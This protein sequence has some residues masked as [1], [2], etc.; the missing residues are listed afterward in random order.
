[1]SL[2]TYHHKRS[3]S[4]TPEPKGQPHT[5]KSKPLHFVVQ[6]HHASRLHYDFRLEMEGVLKSWAIPKGPTMDPDDKPLAVQVEDHPFEYRTFEGVIPEGQYGAGTVAIWDEGTYSS[7]E[8]GKD[9]EKKLLAGLKKG[10][11]KFRLFGKKLQ[12]EFALVQFGDEKKHWLLI[13]KKDSVAEQQKIVPT[14]KSPMPHDISPMLASNGEEAFTNDEWLYEIKWDGYRAVAEVQKGKVRLYSRNQQDFTTTYPNV[15]AELQTLPLD[16]VLDGE[17]VALDKDGKSQ[18]QLM[19]G[20]KNGNGA[21]IMYYVF[22]LLY[23]D[24]YDVRSLPLIERKNLL[25]QFLPP[26]P[27]IKFSEHIDTYG[28]ELFALAKKRNIEGIMAKKKQSTYVSGRSGLWQKIKHINM[29]E[30]IIC[31]Y[32][33]PNGQRKGFGALIL[34]VYSHGELQYVGHTGSGFDDEKLKSIIALL[35]PHVTSKLPFHTEPETNSVPTWVKPKIVCQIKFT[36]WTKEGLMR[37]PIYLGLRLDKKPEEVAREIPEKTPIDTKVPLSNLTKMYWPEDGYTKGDLIAYYDRMAEYILP[38]LIDRPQSLN[39]HP[40]GIHG[41]SF[42]QKDQRTIPDWLKTVKIYSNSDE[43][44][45]NWLLCNDRETLLYMANLGCIEINPWSSRHQKKEYP[46]YL[47]IDLDPNGVA[48]S[49]VVKIAKFIKLMLDKAAI[50]GF[51]KTS[52]KS[53]LHILLPLGGKYTFEQTRTFAELLA[54]TVA[55]AFPE[56]TSIVRDP[57]K[58]EKKIYIDYLQ[59]RMGQTLAAPYSLR[60]VRFAQVSTP[61]AWDEL[62]SSLHPSDFTIKNIFRRLGKSGDIWEPFRKHKGIDMLKSLDLL[63]KYFPQNKP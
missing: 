25:K 18:F 56:I 1:M 11:L 55:Y 17:I 28:E 32:T 63:I 22:D 12:G 33:Q 52:G 58:R 34:G 38:Y 16:A 50:D 35:K 23:L 6:E 8:P 14:K 19:Q 10:D 44:Y 39:R 49:E 59:N 62:K 43:K 29:Q 26:S 46:D 15:V 53:G 21:T 60:P 51:L 30:A 41:E 47:I 40:D 48:F 9:Q 36:E 57:K 7:I 61:L 45:L 31:G 54:R 4:K 37:H 3:F 20:Y 42:Y 24:G 5:A 27:H 13:K 2:S